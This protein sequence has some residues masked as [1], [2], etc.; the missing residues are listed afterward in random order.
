MPVLAICHDSPRCLL[1][2]NLPA[3][4]SEHLDNFGSDGGRQGDADKDEALVDRICER[5]L[6]GQA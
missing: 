6:R 3:P 5:K 1:L 2:A 4:G